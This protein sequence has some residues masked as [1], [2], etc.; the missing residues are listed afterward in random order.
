MLLPM[1]YFHLLHSCSFPCDFQTERLILQSL[2]LLLI[3]I[4][5]SCH[6]DVYRQPRMLRDFAVFSTTSRRLATG[7][8]ASFSCLDLFGTITFDSRPFLL[9]ATVIRL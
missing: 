4:D 1:D 5:P 9:N 6:F 2:H 8:L 7:Q 3:T